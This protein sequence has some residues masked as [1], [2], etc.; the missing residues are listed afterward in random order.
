[1]FDDSELDDLEG[2]DKQ[3]MQ[4]IN[5]KIEIE[6]GSHEASARDKESRQIFQQETP[7][8]K[9]RKFTFQNVSYVH[10]P[11]CSLKINTVLK[12]LRRVLCSTF[13]KVVI[14]SQWTS[15]LTL[16]GRN[17][18]AAHIKH[19]QLTGE[20]TVKKRKDIVE[21]FNTTN[22][23]RVSGFLSMLH[24]S[25]REKKTNYSL[26]ALQVLL[27]SLVAGGVGLNLTGANHLILMEPHWNPQLE[28]Q[29]QDRVYRIG[30]KRP[31]RIYK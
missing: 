29:A 1:M 9:V 5:G 7:S 4:D 24:A 3:V 12:I 30:Q 21:S 19:V 2:Q 13:D 14:V 15:M 31:V 25:C 22:N 10:F 20:T 6:D 28:A 8:S 11:H 16:I 23:E 26:C 17:L 18:T 27:L